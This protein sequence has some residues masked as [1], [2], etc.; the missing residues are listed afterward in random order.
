MTKYKTKIRDRGEL[1]IPKE[2]RERYHLATK[3]EIEFI[4]KI[5]G[6][7]IKRKC[8]DPVSEI[9]GLT[10]GVW[11]RSLSS[12]EI[13]RDIRRRADFETRESP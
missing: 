10:S 12:I 11:P 1:T 2:L 8:E 9:K 7:L 5:E 6:I 13:V 3:T 4:P